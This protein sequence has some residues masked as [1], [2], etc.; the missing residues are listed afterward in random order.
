LPFS[1]ISFLCVSRA[2]L[3]VNYQ[4]SSFLCIV[5]QLSDIDNV[6]HSI[7]LAPMALD[8]SLYLGLCALFWA[9][10]AYIATPTTEY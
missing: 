5:L 9:G 1:N 3:K 2:L 8:P 10:R 6:I 7:L 4:V